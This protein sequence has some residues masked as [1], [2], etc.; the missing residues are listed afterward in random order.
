MTGMALGCELRAAGIPCVFD[1]AAAAKQSLPRQLSEL[2]RAG[3]RVA[4]LVGPDESRQGTAVV[5]NM[6]SRER[7]S[8]PRDSLARH[9][10][11]LLQTLTA[12]KQ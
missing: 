3:G 5:V 12:A 6:E 10:A 7:I 2:A 8:V 11:S 9:L 1:P 4:V